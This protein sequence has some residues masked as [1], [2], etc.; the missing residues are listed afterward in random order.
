MARPK[1]TGKYRSG[2]IKE[3]NYEESHPE[4]LYH[5]MSEG[6]LAIEI[7]ADFKISQDTF[8]R[9]KKEHKNF[10]E[11]F[12]LGY[13]ACYT[14]WLNQGRKN[15]CTSDKG[16]KTWCMIMNNCFGWKDKE[17]S[18]TNNFQINSQTHI[19][20]FNQLSLQNQTES[21]L[22]QTLKGNLQKLHANTQADLIALNPDIKNII[23]AEFDSGSTDLET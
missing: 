18:T 20:S 22:L 7:M 10:E 23:E 12:N 5:L 16:S 3:A 21:Q 14:W 9:W 11:A 1:G 13:P 2:T 8:Y 19:G 6:K 15:M 17:P 4:R